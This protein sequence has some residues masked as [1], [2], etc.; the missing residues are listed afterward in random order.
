[1]PRAKIQGNEQ[2]FKD[3]ILFK[4][5]FIDQ[6]LSGKKNSTRRIGKKRWNVG[7]RHQLKIS[8]FAQPFAIAE[9][10]GVRQEKLGDI[11]EAD[12]ESEGFDTPAEFIASYREIHNLTETDDIAETQVWVVEFRTVE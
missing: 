5:R 7:S 10:N 2:G 4:K 6:I 11:S 9:I 3:V 8:Y 12:A 1:M